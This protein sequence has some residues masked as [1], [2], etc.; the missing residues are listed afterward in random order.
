[1]KP[2]AQESLDMLKA[3]QI[4]TFQI[5]RTVAIVGITLFA[6]FYF[7]LPPPPDTTF[8]SI[9]VTTMDVFFPLAHAFR[10]ATGGS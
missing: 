1:M 6:Y 7:H 9:P 4:T 8:L 5:P 2:E 10:N 3:P